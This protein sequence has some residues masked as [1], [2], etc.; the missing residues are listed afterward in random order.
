MSNP[1]KFAKICQI[2]RDGIRAIKFETARLHVLSDILEAVDI[3]S[4]LLKL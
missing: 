2:E 1:E 4:R 3:V